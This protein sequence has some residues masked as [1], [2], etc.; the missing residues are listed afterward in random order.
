MLW[1]YSTSN[2]DL[3]TLRVYGVSAQG[4]KFP[5]QRV[6]LQALEPSLRIKMIGPEATQHDLTVAYSLGPRCVPVV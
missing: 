3:W 2:P 5:A 4:G 1:R 6:E